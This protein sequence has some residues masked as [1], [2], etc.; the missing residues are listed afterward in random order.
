MRQWK[1]ARF[2]MIGSCRFLVDMKKKEE[3]IH[4]AVCKYLKLAYPDVIFTSESSGIRVPMHT[5]IQM[6]KQ[7]SEKGLPDLLILEPNKFWRGLFIEI[8]KDHSEVFKKDGA[9]RNNKH[10]QE[11][12]EIINR[13]LVKRYFCTFGFGFDHIKEIIDEYMEHR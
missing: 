5:A 8:K 6:K 12:N 4:V 7:R 9:M 10:I 13:L 1:N 11:Q 3:K 2:G